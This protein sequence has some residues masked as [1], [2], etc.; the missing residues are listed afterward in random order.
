MNRE[1]LFSGMTPDRVW[2]EGDLIHRDKP[3]L[4]PQIKPLGAPAEPVIE[5]T[6]GQFS[7][8]F[9]KNEKRIFD[10]HKIK[11]FQPYS[12]KWEEGFVKWDNAWSCFAIFKKFDNEFAHES[13]WV[14]IQEIEIIGNIHDNPELLEGGGK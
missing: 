14:K 9:D 1:I 13:D 2:I 7:G 8:Q 11:Y 10:G 5:S 12:N 3:G 6:V 4:S